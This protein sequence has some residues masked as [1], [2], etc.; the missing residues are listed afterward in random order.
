MRDCT[1][2]NGHTG[3]PPASLGVN[4]T[5]WL[6][7]PPFAARLVSSVTHGGYV[8]PVV[9]GASVAPF[10]PLRWHG[11]HAAG[12]RHSGAGGMVVIS[13]TVPQAI[14]GTH[15]LIAA[16]ALSFKSASTPFTV[17][18]K[19]YQFHRSGPQG[20]FN[21]FDGYGFASFE[22]VQARWS[23]TKGQVLATSSTDVVGAIAAPV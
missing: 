11:H 19:T 16:G 22:P 13:L 8:D 1:Q 2:D 7:A 17:T 20:S 9:T 5:P 3:R 14:A 15:T 6:D 18:P 10:E 4:F 21:I 23:S 12:R